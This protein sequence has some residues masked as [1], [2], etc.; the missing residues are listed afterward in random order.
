MFAY[1]FFQLFRNLSPGSSV[2]VE[3]FLVKSP[4]KGQNVELQATRVDVLGP[5][6]MEVKKMPY[7]HIIYTSLVPS[8]DILKLKVLKTPYICYF[9]SLYVCLYTHLIFF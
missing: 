2:E 5:C 1:P 8:F 7:Q 6:N 9:V 3:G 4:K